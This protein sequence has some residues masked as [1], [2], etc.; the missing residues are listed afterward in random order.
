MCPIGLILWRKIV[1]DGQEARFTHDSIRYPCR[2]FITTSVQRATHRKTRRKLA[3]L[4]C[5]LLVTKGST[6]VDTSQHRGNKEQWTDISCGRVT[7]S[8]LLYIPE[9]TKPVVPPTAASTTVNCDPMAS[10]SLPG[11]H[12]V[13]V[14]I[15][16]PL[17]PMITLFAKG[18]ATRQRE[19]ATSLW[20]A[21]ACV[22]PGCRRWSAR[23]IGQS[24]QPFG[25][26]CQSAPSGVASGSGATSLRRAR[27]R[28]RAPGIV[29]ARGARHGAMP[30]CVCFRKKSSAPRR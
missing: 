28:G 24:L 26:E 1:P 23:L 17:A 19:P 4:C 5:C 22:A 14:P 15:N 18:S 6:F 2:K 30:S 3:Q 29:R 27:N 21:S 25:Y 13:A 12:P 7:R 16:E 10:G 8:T 9:K 11:S 20:A